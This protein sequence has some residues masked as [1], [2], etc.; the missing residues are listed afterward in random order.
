MLP[1]FCN[2]AVTV[3]RAGRKESRGSKVM[4][5]SSATART[6]AGCSV[7]DGGTSLSLDGHTLAVAEDATLY[8]PE[9]ADVAAGDRVSLDGRTWTVNGAPRVMRSATGAVSHI[10]APLQAWEA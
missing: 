9:G 4:D 8:A 1:S 6:I 2:D 5:W 10:E 3:T 7:Q